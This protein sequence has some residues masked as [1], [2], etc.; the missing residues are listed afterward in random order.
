MVPPPLS[1]RDL[2]RSRKRM[3]EEVT[4]QVSVWEEDWSER[5]VCGR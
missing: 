4:N 1:F 5:E 2:P 3:E